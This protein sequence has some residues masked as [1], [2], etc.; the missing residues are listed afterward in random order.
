L[1]YA[2]FDICPIVGLF[3]H[4][5][6]KGKKDDFLGVGISPRVSLSPLHALALSNPVFMNTYKWSK[7]QSAFPPVLCIN[8]WAVRKMV[9]FGT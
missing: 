5:E 6:K 4:L 2:G 1:W 8:R 3:E 9:L 7:G